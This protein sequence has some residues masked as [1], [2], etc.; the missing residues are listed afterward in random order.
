MFNELPLFRNAK[1][2]IESLRPALA[3]L[4]DIIV[5]HNLEEDIGINLLHRHFDLESG[6]ILLKEVFDDHAVIAPRA[7]STPATPYLF[8]VTSTGLVPTEYIAPNSMYHGQVSTRMAALNKC[9]ELFEAITGLGL[10]DKLGIFLR[11]QEFAEGSDMAWIEDSAEGR[12]LVIRKQRLTPNVQQSLT[13]T[14]WFFKKSMH[15]PDPQ[16][17]VFC[18]VCCLVHCGIHCGWHG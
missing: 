13:E 2:E 14:N 11:H 12:E 3:Q 17:G 10:A 8:K 15:S 16:A 18:G 4:G 1:Q 9:P 5:R 6:E 7:A